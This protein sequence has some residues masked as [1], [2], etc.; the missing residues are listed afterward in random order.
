MSAI[1]FLSAGAAIAIGASLLVINTLRWA[2][3]VVTVGRGRAL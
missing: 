1:L 2:A 3:R